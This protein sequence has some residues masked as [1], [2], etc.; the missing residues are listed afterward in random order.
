[1][2]NRN[3]FSSVNGSSSK[4]A[5]SS[6][7]RT[8]ATPKS[9]SKG[10]A[11]DTNEPLAKPLISEIIPQEF[12]FIADFAERNSDINK[13][14]GHMSMLTFIHILS[15]LAIFPSFVESADENLF[16]KLNLLVKTI[17]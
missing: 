16:F 6:R 3:H 15:S 2:V 9:S 11:N 7:T 1:M 5:S 17:E 14:E 4:Y 8:T 12:T 10:K 13:K